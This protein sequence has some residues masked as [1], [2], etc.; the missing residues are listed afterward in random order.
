VLTT[1]PAPRVEKSGDAIV[2]PARDPIGLRVL[3]I[4]FTI[5]ATVAA[6]TLLARW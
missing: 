1:Q 4:L 3:V 6:A 5:A 2:A